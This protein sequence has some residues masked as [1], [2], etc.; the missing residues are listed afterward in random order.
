MIE[1]Q[2]LRTGNKIERAILV[3]VCS[4]GVRF[5]QAKEYLDELAF[6][7]ETAGAKGGEKF[8][9]KTRQTC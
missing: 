8:Y 4:R 5:E 2:T 6:L 1:K 9:S 3:G 7:A